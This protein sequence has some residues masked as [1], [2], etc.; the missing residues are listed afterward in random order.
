MLTGFAVGLVVGMV[1]VIV[2]YELIVVTSVARVSKDALVD[3]YQQIEQQTAL[4]RTVK[5]QLDKSTTTI[6]QIIWQTL[7]TES[8]SRH[9]H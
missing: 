2:Y 8:H 1:A 6:Q 9:V 4:L 7:P 5:D 3:A